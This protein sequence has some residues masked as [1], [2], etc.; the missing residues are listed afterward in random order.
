MA[1]R[2]HDAS[3][4]PG[5]TGATLQRDPSPEEPEDSQRDELFKALFEAALPWPTDLYL[6]FV[7][8][9]DLLVRMVQRFDASND[10]LEIVVDH[11]V[12]GQRIYDALKDACLYA[13]FGDGWA[14][15]CDVV[16]E[17]MEEME[18]MHAIGHDMDFATVMY[19]ANRLCGDERD[20]SQDRMWAHETGSGM[21]KL[22]EPPAS[23]DGDVR[24]PKRGAGM[25]SPA[26]DLWLDP[27]RR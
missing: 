19:R 6:H 24:K 7:D 3:I 13:Q 25:G 21:R 20:I 9:T 22:A 12:H 16:L 11:V 2:A 4:T 27:P 5:E 26:R 10:I 8:Q 18:E 1:Q 14:Q 23:T 17:V 15:C